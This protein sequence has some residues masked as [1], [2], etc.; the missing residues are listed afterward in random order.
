MGELG[1]FQQ[2][3]QL[4][5]LALL[6]CQSTPVLYVDPVCLCVL[7]SS[8]AFRRALQLRH[9]PVTRTASLAYDALW[10]VALALRTAQRQWRARGLG[11]TLHRFD[12]SH[13]GTAADLFTATQRLNFTGVSVRAA[14]LHRSPW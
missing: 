12:Y 1:S 13:A 2:P 9:V 7:Q 6:E 4:S 5:R 3:L 8:A 11:R 10:S 14:Q